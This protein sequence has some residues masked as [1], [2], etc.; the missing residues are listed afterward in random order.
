MQAPSPPSPRAR[1]GLLSR[2][3]GEAIRALWGHDPASLSPLR[4][5]ALVTARL[6]FL[7]LAAF[8]RERL[9]IRAG[10][11]AFATLLALVP[12]AALL[13]SVAKAVGAYDALVRTSIRP[14]LEEVFAADPNQPLP[15]G[16][17]MLH[18]TLD[19]LLTAVAETDVW[20]LGIAGLVL[21]AF[22]I[23]RVLHGSEEAFDAVWGFPSHRPLAVSFPSFILVAVVTA[24]TLVLASTLTAARTQH[25][26]MA[27]VRQATGIPGLVDGV[28]FFL[29][30]LLVILALLTAYMLLPSAPVRLRSA[31]VGALVGGL[32]WYALLVV[33]VRFQVGVA[34]YNALYAGFGAFPIFLVWLHLSWVFILLG[35]QAAAAHQNAP[36]YRQLARGRFVDHFTRQAVALRAMVELAEQDQP[37]RLRSLAHRLG[38]GVEALREVLDSLVGHGLLE[39]HGTGF[40]P[41]YEPAS[42]PD[43]IRVTEVLDA[44]ERA[45]SPPELTVPLRGDEEQM[46]AVLEGL[47]NAADAS[48]HNRT[49]AELCQVTRDSGT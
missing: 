40:D 31:L 16:M 33:H 39:A 36:T 27:W 21:V 26:L 28:A 47:Q 6:A 29:P 43:Q 9:Q 49:I 18:Q 19:G 4:R 48:D 37:M 14:W 17:V 22:A 23:L 13:F 3:R 11:L 20:S 15:E 38:V 30:P 5:R 42:D 1:P 2:L 7:T 24:P 35:A 8:F 44:L 10:S 25:A 41:R 46:A 12:S 32:C 34:R 45:T